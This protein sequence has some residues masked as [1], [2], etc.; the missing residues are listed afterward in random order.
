[1]GKLSDD[2]YSE[3]HWSVS[4][5]TGGAGLRGRSSGQS[6]RQQ[7]ERDLLSATEAL[8]KKAPL[9]KRSGRV[10]EKPIEVDS[11]K[12]ENDQRPTV[13]TTACPDCGLTPGITSTYALLQKLAVARYR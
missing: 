11:R 9:G 8:R 5:R 3:I 12:T 4:E 13:V 10:T 1:M 6:T 7:I 2:D